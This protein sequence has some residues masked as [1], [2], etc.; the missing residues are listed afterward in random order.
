MK[1]LT[2]AQLLAE[3]SDRSGVS[4]HL[5]VDVL[6]A[7]RD[8]V[9]EQLK[10]VGAVTIPDMVRFTLRDKPATPERKGINH[11]TGEPTVFKAKPASKMV[12]AAPV[13]A[14]KDAVK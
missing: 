9:V 14:I 1:K 12:K 4:K 5:V 10:E 8:V 3:V 11:F 6:F 2:K 7:L 13:K